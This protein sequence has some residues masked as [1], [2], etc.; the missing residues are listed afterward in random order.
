MFG[1]RDLLV[2]QRYALHQFDSID[3]LLKAYAPQIVEGQTGEGNDGSTI[4]RR[5]VK[6]VHQMDRARSRRSDT[7]AKTSGVLRESRCHERGGFL[8]ADPD[9]ANTI[10]ALTQGF[11]D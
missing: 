4:E 1:S 10:L 8:V 7:D 9:V 3:P 2:V 5:L 6:P 11:N